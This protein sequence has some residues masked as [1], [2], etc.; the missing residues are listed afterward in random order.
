MNFKVGDKVRIT[1]PKT[2]EWPGWAPDM[3]NFLN[4]VV[5]I[6][7]VRSRCV[8]LKGDVRCWNFKKEWCKKVGGGILL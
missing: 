5:V 1:K 7:D 6:R 3:D 4:K 8:C 2:D